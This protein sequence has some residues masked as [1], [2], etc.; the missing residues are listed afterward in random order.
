MNATP[1][2]I[3][4]RRGNAGF[5]LLELITAMAVSSLLIIMLLNAFKQT[6]KAWTAGEAQVETYQIG[7]VLLD[8]IAQDLSQVRVTKS[9]KFAG[10]AARLDFY[11]ATAT[12]GTGDLTRIIYY[13]DAGATPRVLY[14][15]STNYPAA[16][17]TFRPVFS[18]NVISCTF[19]YYENVNGILQPKASYPSGTNVPSAVLVTVGI[20]DSRTAAQYADVQST[21]LEKA[22][23]RSFSEMIHLPCSLP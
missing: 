15:T 1:Q 10:S 2:L 13:Y 11:A 9:C 19:R 12:G 6:S 3:R 7:R 21:A 8:L 5:T 20:L 23:M 17:P 14:R 4:F 18:N 16:L 22:N